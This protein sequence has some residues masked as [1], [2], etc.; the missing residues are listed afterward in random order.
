MIFCYIRRVNIQ[1]SCCV[2]APALRP[3]GSGIMK[4]RFLLTLFIV[5]GTAICSHSQYIPMLR[6]GTV[7][8]EYAPYGTGMNYTITV[9]GDTVIMQTMYKIVIQDPPGLYG[10]SRHY[11]REDTAEKKI[12]EFI[13]DFPLPYE[14]ILYDFDVTVG[15][16]IMVQ[17]G[18][19]L[20]LTTV[21]DSVPVP[22]VPQDSVSCSLSPLRVFQFDILG[23]VGHAVWIEGI[24]SL[25]GLYGSI[26]PWCS[27]NYLLCHSDSVLTQDYYYFEHNQVQP[28]VG[29]LPVPQPLKRTPLKV[30]PNPCAQGTLMI[31]GQDLVRARII[32]LQGQSVQEMFL[33]NREMN[34]VSL[35]LPPGIYF[36]E[37]FTDYGERAVVKLFIN[38]YR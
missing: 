10:G 17:G 2:F 25:T 5:I 1:Y 28:C 4:T 20:V 36:L 26:S 13:Y 11:L 34:R 19:E 24:G 21:Y 37:A 16:H 18:Y 3:V 30:Y 23:L 27:G 6:N 9:A 35:A 38:E 32:N 33:D 22:C 8:N 15:N 29:I 7:W 14:E 12:F 31:T